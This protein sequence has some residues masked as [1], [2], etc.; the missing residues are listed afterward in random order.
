MVIYPFWASLIGQLCSQF[1]PWSGNRALYGVICYTLHNTIHCWCFTQFNTLLLSRV[2][3]R[4][5]PL[6]VC[7]PTPLT[8]LILFSPS[9]N[10]PSPSSSSLS[11]PPPLI[12]PVGLFE[13]GGN[14]LLRCPANH[15][16]REG[17]CIPCD[18]PCPTG[19]KGCSGF[20][21]GC[22]INREE[23]ICYQLEFGR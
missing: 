16:P 20:S 21:V 4:W 14:C 7:L 10:R 18:G 11:S 5:L 19:K 15:F 13:L 8:L 2:L 3:K 6:I 9:S 22:C 1:S 12:H 17:Q 23:F